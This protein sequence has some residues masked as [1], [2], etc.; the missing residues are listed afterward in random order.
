MGWCDSLAPDY[1]GLRCRYQRRAGALS[2]DV[3]VELREDERR[4]IVEV[5][6]QRGESDDVPQGFRIP[7][8][9]VHDRSPEMGAK[10]CGGCYCLTDRYIL[11]PRFQMTN[12]SRLP[13]EASSPLI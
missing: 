4:E 13:A 12:V 5:Q 2:L 3:G 7:P 11:F 1:F 10:E 9:D 6:V 8:A